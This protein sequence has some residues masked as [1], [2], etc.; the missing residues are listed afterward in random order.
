MPLRGFGG[1][2]IGLPAM[3]VCRV[4]RTWQIVEIII[5]V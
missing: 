3:P 2:V 1:E 5:V 4:L